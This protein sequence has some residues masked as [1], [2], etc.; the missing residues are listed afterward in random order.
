MR[1][2]LHWTSAAWVRPSNEAMA[3]AMLLPLALAL[4]MKSNCHD[5]SCG[6]GW[7]AKIGSLSGASNEECC[8]RSV[9]KPNEM[10]KTRKTFWP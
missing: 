7:T 3:H 9:E 4:K 2:Q 1:R 5:W 8:D 6:D 10:I